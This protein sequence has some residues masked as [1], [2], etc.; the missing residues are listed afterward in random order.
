MFDG[1]QAKSG[2]LGRGS[3]TGEG[4]GRVYSAKSTGTQAGSTDPER[5]DRA[6]T[7]L[8]G[9]FGRCS[10]ANRR[11]RGVWGEVARPA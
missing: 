8:D 7:L 3:Q 9:V 4:T 2:N 10:T 5:S 6:W 11:S 1:Q